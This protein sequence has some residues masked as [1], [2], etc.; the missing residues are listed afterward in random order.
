MCPC[1]A[2]N[3][4]AYVTHINFRMRPGTPLQ[5]C[6]SQSPTDLS[7]QRQCLH[8][9]P[10]IATAFLCRTRFTRFYPTQFRHDR[11]RDAFHNQASDLSQQRQSLHRQSSIEEAEYQLTSIRWDGPRGAPSGGPAVPP[12]GRPIHWGLYL[13]V[14]RNSAL[15]WIRIMSV[16]PR[17]NGRLGG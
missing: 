7:Q 13:S 17:Q 1:P 4:S 11:R 5:F 16:S 12:S 14:I 2:E 9:H 6:S 8:S 3:R 15:R 10:S